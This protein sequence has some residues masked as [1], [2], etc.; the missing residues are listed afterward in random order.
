MDVDSLSLKPGFS[1]DCKVFCTCE[2]HAAR[3]RLALPTCVMVFRDN[4][5]PHGDFAGEER[6]G[7]L[8][9][10]ARIE[11]V[12]RCFGTLDLAVGHHSAY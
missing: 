3:T 11:D 10:L 4:R 12:E 6:N 1:V 8:G 9:D 5:R 7:F 2:V